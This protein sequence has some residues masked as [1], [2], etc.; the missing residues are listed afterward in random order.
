MRGE[1][2]VRCAIVI[3]IP[4]EMASELGKGSGGSAKAKARISP[5]ST[6]EVWLS[7][8]TYPFRKENELGLTR[9]SLIT[10]NGS[11]SPRFQCQQVAYLGRLMVRL[12]SLGQDPSKPCLL[13]FLNVHLIKIKPMSMT[14]S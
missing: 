4:V 12:V 7:G 3:S 8:K 13:D 5:S 14:N 1:E 11:P 10:I 9:M 6:W 2:P